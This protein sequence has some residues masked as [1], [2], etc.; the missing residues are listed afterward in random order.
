MRSNQSTTDQPVTLNRHQ[1]LS[2]RSNKINNTKL[3]L[4]RNPSDNVTNIFVGTAKGSRALTDEGEKTNCE[5]D[6]AQ[7]RNKK[8]HTGSTTV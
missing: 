5:S 6:L 1:F 3:L 4:K 8:Q 2:S 7:K